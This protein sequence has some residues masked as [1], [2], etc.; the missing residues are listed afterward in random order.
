MLVYHVFVRIIIQYVNDLVI[1]TNEIGE[2]EQGV[3]E[4]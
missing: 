2:Q 4:T 1:F 3:D